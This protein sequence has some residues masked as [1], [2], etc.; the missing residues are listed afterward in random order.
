M[1]V[2]F[3]PQRLAAEFARYE[4][5]MNKKIGRFY[6]KLDKRLNS[7]NTAVDD[8]ECIR[9]ILTHLDKYGPHLWDHLNPIKDASGNIVSYRIVPRTNN[10]LESYFHILKHHERR[11]C[12]RT[13][14]AWDLECLNPASALVSNLNDPEYLRIVCDGSLENLQ[15]LFSEIDQ[16]ERDQRKQAEHRGIETSAPMKTN[17]TAA[18]KAL[19]RSDS[20]DELIGSM[21]P[22]NIGEACPNY[23][24]M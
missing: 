13:R 9:I 14:M 3:E 1:Q 24:F 20:F 8:K 19:A 6:A 22:H 16:G 18:C 17:M 4:E 10:L 7:R 5:A 12:G 15:R 2:G 23:R 21:L 11:R